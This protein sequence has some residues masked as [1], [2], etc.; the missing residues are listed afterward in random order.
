MTIGSVLLGLALLLLVVMY[1]ARPLL[2]TETRRR[3]RMRSRPNNRQ[4][5]LAQKEALL[6]QIHELDF[7][8]ETGKLHEAD[9]GQQRAAL[10]FQATAVL[11]Q[12]DE[13]DG[14]IEAGAAAVREE[15]DASRKGDRDSE[16]EAAVARLRESTPA[17]APEIA[18]K[19]PAQAGNGLANC[20]RYLCYYTPSTFEATLLNSQFC[21]YEGT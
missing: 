14:E 11:K 18:E 15:A 1:I 2:S 6:A 9:Y 17:A 7:D 12:I 10:M 8:F 21:D 19:E 13:F 4:S 3:L 16:I 5:L 20:C